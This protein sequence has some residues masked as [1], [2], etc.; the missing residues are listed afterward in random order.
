MFGG[1]SNDM[2]ITPWIRAMN[3]YTCMRRRRRLMCGARAAPHYRESALSPASITPLSAARSVTGGRVCA[4]SSFS[5][6]A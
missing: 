4:T 5:A 2:K 6:S 3:P 1:A